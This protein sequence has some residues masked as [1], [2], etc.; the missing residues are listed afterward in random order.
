MK[1]ALVDFH[2]LAEVE[3]VPVKDIVTEWHRSTLNGNEWNADTDVKVLW[4]KKGQKVKESAVI[5]IL[6][7]AGTRYLLWFQTFNKAP[8]EHRKNASSRTTCRQEMLSQIVQRVHDS[9]LY[10][11]VWVKK[12]PEVFWHLHTVRRVR[13]NFLFKGTTNRI[14]H[15]DTTEHWVRTTWHPSVQSQPTRNCSSRFSETPWAG[16][17]WLEYSMKSVNL[18]SGHSH[19]AQARSPSCMTS[20]LCCKMLPTPVTMSEMQI[21]TFHYVF[22]NKNVQ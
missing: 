1:F 13:G 11:T 19:T 3:L 15:H 21:H 10:S 8:E 5:K 7:L 18:A 6:R 16:M 14:R 20:P 12:S 22:V 17:R 4:L 9:R 2:E